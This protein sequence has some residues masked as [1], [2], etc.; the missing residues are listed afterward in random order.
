MT[1]RDVA[2]ASG[3]SI[4]TVSRILNGRESG[5][6][7]RDETRQR[8]LAVA[9]EMGYKPNLLARGLRGSR[10][11][12]LGVIARDISRPVPYPDPARDQRRGSGA[13]LPAVPRPRR[14]SAR[15]GAHLRLDVR[16]IARRRDHHHRRHRRRRLDPGGVRRAASLRPRRHRPDRAPPDPRRL[17]RQPGRHE[18]GARA[19]V[20]PRSSID[21]LRVGRAD[22]RRAAPDRSL[23]AV[24]AGA[25]RRGPDRGPRLRA[26]PRS[27]PRA[28]P[29]GSSP[30]SIRRLRRRR[31]SRP[32]T[33][34]RW[35]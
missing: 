6:P 4:T 20:G 5:V 23:Q 2:Q 30:P 12:L 21:R 32:P 11:S 22:L 34:S 28:G 29:S 31:S 3:V 8:V 13:R 19:P 14:L 25:R 35:A 9:A 26:G 10:S 33:R 7:I 18:A 15:R 1:L 24:H 27:R 16:A 17:R